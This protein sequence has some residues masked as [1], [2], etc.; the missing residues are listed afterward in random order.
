MLGQPEHNVPAASHY[1]PGKPSVLG[2]NYPQVE[3]PALEH[4]LLQ[5]ITRSLVEY[6]EDD[7]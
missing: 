5:P 4:E 2:G 1:P 7:M 6:L 3:N